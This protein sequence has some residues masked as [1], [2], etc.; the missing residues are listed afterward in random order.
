MNLLSLVHSLLSLPI[1]FASFCFFLESPHCLFMLISILH[2]CFCIE[3]PHRFFTQTCLY[4]LSLP[5]FLLFLPSSSPYQPLCPLHPHEHRFIECTQH[6]KLH[7]HTMMMISNTLSKVKIMTEKMA[8]WMV[9]YLPAGNV[10]T[11]GLCVCV[12]LIMVEFVPG[13]LSRRC[14]C[15]RWHHNRARCSHETCQVCSLDQRKAEF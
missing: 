8:V 3:T 5:Q 14:L 11:E 7:I 4:S 6:S 9:N 1:I 15:A 10:F 12:C 2:P 13:D